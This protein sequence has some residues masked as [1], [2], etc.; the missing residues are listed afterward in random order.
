MG[1]Y[2]LTMTNIYTT[3]SSVSMLRGQAFPTAIR[4]PLYKT[5][6]HGLRD[7]NPEAAAMLE[8]SPRLRNP[9]K[10]NTLDRMVKSLVKV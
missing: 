3:H 1:V 2:S 5:L 10:R 8:A 4:R 6:V 9:T 7:V